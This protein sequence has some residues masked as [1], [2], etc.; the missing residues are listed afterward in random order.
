MLDVTAGSTSS[1]S[2]ASPVIGTAVSAL[3]AILA[4]DPTATPSTAALAA[5]AGVSSR[6]LQ[7][8]LRTALGTRPGALARRLRLA[9]A[10]ETLMAGEVPSVTEAALQHGFSNQ[11]RFAAAYAAA[12]GETPSATLRAARARHAGGPAARSSGPLI[13]LRPVQG[14]DPVRS[15]RA[16]DD[17]AAA[18]CRIRDLALR[19]PMTPLAVADAQRLFRLEARLDPD[20]IVVTLVHP[21]R[22]VV[23]W[24]GHEPL[25]RGDGVA[26]PHR[27]AAAIRG[28]VE[29]ARLAEARRASHR[30][31]DADTL[32]TRARPAALS[33]ERGTVAVAL[34]LLN[35]AL[36]RDPAHP[37]AHALAAWSHAQSAMHN[38]VKD[39]KAERE[40]AHDHARRAV[41]IAPDDPEVLTHAAA[42]MSLTHRLDEAERLA[43]RAVALDPMMAEAQRRLGWIR[44][45]QGEHAAA[46]PVFQRTL[47]LWPDGRNASLALVGIGTSLLAAGED[48]RAAR[49]LSRALSIRPTL[50][51]VNRMLT[52]AAIHDGAMAEAQRSL[53]ALQR[54]FPDIT[55]SQVGRS[56]VLDPATMDRLP[57]GLGRA[58]LPR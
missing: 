9:A 31:A 55:V 21:G 28:A 33:L 56:M 58:G 6:T 3:R 44:L 4:A 22:G 40:R 52:A 12:F 27:A 50:T 15:R 46:L 49:A 11:G 43:M 30:S 53:V 41:A 14:A 45:Y 37:I 48:S 5:T 47:R 8:R 34:D 51:W 24:V 17:L 16:T 18:L 19:D 13:D 39:P 29:D 1:S 10:R 54:A 57:R 25:A 32:V 35:D 36:H 2:E 38:F 42:V 26:W 20:R 23:V 7:R